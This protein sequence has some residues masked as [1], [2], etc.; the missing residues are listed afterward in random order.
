LLGN[1]AIISISNGLEFAKELRVAPSAVG[2]GKFAD[3]ICDGLVARMIR[4][5]LREG[6]YQTLAVAGAA[7]L[8]TAPV[9]FYM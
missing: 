4:A 2:A 8:A 3:T 7:T 5:V 6:R 9:R 1:A